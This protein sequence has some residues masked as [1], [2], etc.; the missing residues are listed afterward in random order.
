MRAVSSAKASS[1]SSS[2]L[3]WAGNST[4]SISWKSDGTHV[5]SHPCRWEVPCSSGRLERRT[6]EYPSCLSFQFCPGADPKDSA[7]EWREAY[8]I[9]CGRG[10]GLDVEAS[11]TTGHR[12]TP[13]RGKR[14]GDAGTVICERR[15]PPGCEGASSN[16][17][18]FHILGFG[19]L[20]P[21]NAFLSNDG[22]IE[23]LTNSVHLRI[24]T[25][26]YARS[27]V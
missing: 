5:R 1:S 21:L 2:S 11:F 26:R 16:H 15:I 25:G 20:P 8:R 23:L 10:I 6:V 9:R 22:L 3:S 27:K 19:T 18:A 24:A 12:L 14:L 17:G 7:S 13:H 4:L